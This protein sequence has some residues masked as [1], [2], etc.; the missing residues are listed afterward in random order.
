MDN[1]RELKPDEME[2]VTGSV[3]RTVNTGVSGLNAALRDGPSKKGT[4]QIASL[5]NGTQVDTITDQVV[6]DPVSGRN[7]VEVTVNGKR[8]WIAA[9]IIG[10]PR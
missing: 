7:F 9:S 8:G 1:I 3:W 6:Y 10:L 5:P 4:K 2:Q